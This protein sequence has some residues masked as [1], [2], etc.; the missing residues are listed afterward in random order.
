M[1]GRP[2]S[3]PLVKLLTRPGCVT[4]DKAKFVLKKIKAQG[5]D[6]EGKVVNI[7]KERKYIHFNDELPVILVDEE[8][9]CRITVHETTL[10]EA[11]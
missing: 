5:T 4:C 11:I 9:V 7:L 3:L 6:F 10:R 8:P 1:Q 2:N